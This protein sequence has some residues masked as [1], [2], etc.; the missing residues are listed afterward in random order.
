MIIRE[1]F[2]N[3]DYQTLYIEFLMDED[4]E[5]NYRTVELSFI[6]VIYYSPYSIE[7]YDIETLN[8]D[9]IT[10]IIEEYLIENDLPEQQYL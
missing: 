8:V 3:K 4:K 1:F 5:D 6:D 7:E 10:E 9:D 2:I